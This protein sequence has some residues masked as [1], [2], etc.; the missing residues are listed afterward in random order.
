MKNILFFCFLIGTTFSFAQLAFQ[1]RI[2]TLNN[3]AATGVSALSDSGLMIS[4]SYSGGIDTSFFI[5]TDQQGNILWGKKYWADSTQLFSR[6]LKLSNGNF[7][8][9]G[10]NYSIQQPHLIIYVCDSSGNII[11]NKTYSF[12]RKITGES[13]RQTYDAG[14]IIP[15]M[16]DTAFSVSNLSTYG[17]MKVDSIGNVL[18]CKCYQPDSLHLNCYLTRRFRNKTRLIWKYNSCQSI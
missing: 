13:I 16:Y 11:W 2:G 9:W 7:L 4:G 15:F 8:F 6:F 17:L 12:N 1:E 14:F 18:W 5:R 3:D 10:D